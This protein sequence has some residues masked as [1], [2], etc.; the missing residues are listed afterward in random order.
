MLKHCLYPIFVFTKAAS[1]ALASS[2]M[3]LDAVITLTDVDTRS[4]NNA[5]YI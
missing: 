4:E 2:Y 3:T 5:V 1:C